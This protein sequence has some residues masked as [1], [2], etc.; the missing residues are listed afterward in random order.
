MEDF[1]SV[2]GMGTGVAPPVKPPETLI[3]C[4][5]LIYHKLIKIASEKLTKGREKEE[6]EVKAH[7]LLVLV[8]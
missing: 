1:T 4:G 2:F 6:K 7:G 5:L 8:S 3:H